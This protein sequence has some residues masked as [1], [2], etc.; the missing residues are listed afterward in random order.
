MVRFKVSNLVYISI[1]SLKL[2]SGQNR[3]ILVEFI[4]IAQ[5][6]AQFGKYTVGNA[7]SIDGKAIWSALKQSMLNNF[8]ETRWGAVG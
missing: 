7:N 3:W 5:G 4:P 2:G 6:T 1:L 8:G